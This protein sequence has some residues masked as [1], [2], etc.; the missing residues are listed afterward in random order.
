MGWA[1]ASQ[2]DQATEW[3]LPGLLSLTS[4][5]ESRSPAVFSAA[6]RFKLLLHCTCTCKL[7]PHMIALNAVGTASR[8]EKSH[9]YYLHSGNTW[10][11]CM[12]PK[13]LARRNLPKASP[14]AV[15]TSSSLQDVSCQLTVPGASAL[16][17]A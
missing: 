17:I 16:A 14:A 12:G 6:R 11:V 3:P 4:Q 15:T 1:L 5:L 10:L 8:M 13:E 9:T 2:A 7:N